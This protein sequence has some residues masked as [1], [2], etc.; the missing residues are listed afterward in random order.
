M[1]THRPFETWILQDDPLTDDETA[2]LRQHLD[3]CQ[4][5]RSLAEGWTEAAQRLQKVSMRAPRAGFVHRWEAARALQR[6][7]RSRWSAWLAAAGGLGAASA[8]G[9]MVVWELWALMEQPSAALLGWVRDL[10]QWSIVL[11][12]LQDFV[13]ALSRTLPFG[14]IGGLWLGFVAAVGGLLIVWLASLHRT[15]LQGVRS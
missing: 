12:V 8:A 14:L 15:S 10:V 6:V 1:P 7:P 4:A 9:A 11:R 5:C 2:A 3:Q 13:E